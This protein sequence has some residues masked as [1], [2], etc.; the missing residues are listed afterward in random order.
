MPGVCTWG[1]LLAKGGA[2]VLDNALGVHWGS[3]LTKGGIVITKLPE[4]CFVFMPCYSYSF[5]H[6]YL[7]ASL[8]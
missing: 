1:S 4:C 7:T 5:I 3:L 8:R 6:P 2:I